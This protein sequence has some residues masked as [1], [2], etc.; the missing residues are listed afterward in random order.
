[1]V[2]GHI[3]NLTNKQEGENFKEWQQLIRE[4]PFMGRVSATLVANKNKKNSNEP[5]FHLYENIT[6]RGD[7][8]KFNDKTFKPRAIGA[9]WRRVSKNGQTNFLAGSIDT[10]MVYGGKFNFS[11]FETK[12]PDNANADDYFWTYDAVWNPFKKENTSNNYNNSYDYAEPTTYTQGPN[13]NIPVYSEDDLDL[14]R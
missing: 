14:Y 5:D 4:P 10:P 6:K 8:E 7:K 12:I 9:I 13:G 1:M 11:L 2:I 3:V